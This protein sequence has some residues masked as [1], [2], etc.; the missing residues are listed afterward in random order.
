MVTHVPILVPPGIHVS[1]RLQDH[2][3]THAHTACCRDS[4]YALRPILGSLREMGALGSPA[5][6]LG[7]R[8]P[9][10][11]QLPVQPPPPSPA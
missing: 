1:T 9:P 6:S 5:R 3:H 7:S 10:R 4:V 2:T 8:L 11:G